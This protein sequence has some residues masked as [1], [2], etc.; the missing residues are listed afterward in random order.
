EA[1]ENGDIPDIPVV[2]DSPLAVNASDLYRKH[3][4]CFD[5]ETWQYMHEHRMKGLDFDNMIF[6]RS[7]DESKSL[8]EYK[9]PMIIISASGMAE[10]GRILHHLKNNI[11]DGR[12]TI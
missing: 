3:T 7:V 12:N 11:E 1:L 2:I 6:T 9:Q 4:E 8:N 10:S 5:E